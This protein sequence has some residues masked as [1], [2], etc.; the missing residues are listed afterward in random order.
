MNVDQV[1]NNVNSGELLGVFN[2]AAVPAL[3][4]TEA[5]EL[6]YAPKFVQDV[7]P[8]GVMCERCL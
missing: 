7:S 5:G 3:G 2:F 1:E 4:G 6:R 8:L